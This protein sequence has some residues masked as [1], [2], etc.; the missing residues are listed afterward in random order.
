MMINE[1]EATVSCTEKVSRIY[2]PLDIA[3]ETRVSGFAFSRKLA[4]QTGLT[5]KDISRAF[6][7]ALKNSSMPNWPER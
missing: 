5:R 7:W 3:E 2:M 4:R 1:V 6:L